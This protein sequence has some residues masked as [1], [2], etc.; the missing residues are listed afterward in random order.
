MKEASILNISG[1]FIIFIGL[2][3]ARIAALE[4]Y[5]RAPMILYKDVYKIQEPG[6]VICLG[7]EWYRFPSSFF[8][9]E[10]AHARFIKSSFTGQL[11]QRFYENVNGTYAHRRDQNDGNKEE[12]SVYVNIK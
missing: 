8:V 7:K 5:Y 12:P 1:F 9:P 3:I 11:P 6:A 4:S 10:G 2:S